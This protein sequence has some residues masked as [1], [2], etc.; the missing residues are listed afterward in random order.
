MIPGYATGLGEPAAAGKRSL[1]QPP[2]ETDRQP[3]LKNPPHNKH[4]R[5]KGSGSRPPVERLR[6]TIELTPQALRILQ[7]T[8]QAYRLRTGKV[9]PMWKALSQAIERYGKAESVV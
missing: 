8:Q 5:Q 6:T 7:E 9:L 4:I 2:E 1:F 3:V